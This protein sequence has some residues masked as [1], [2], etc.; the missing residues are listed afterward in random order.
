MYWT[1]TVVWFILGLILFWNVLSSKWNR[2]DPLYRSMFRT[3]MILNPIP[4]HE[5][6]LDLKFSVLRHSVV[7]IVSAALIYWF[8][9][10]RFLLNTVLTLNLL[11][12]FSVFSRYR[13]RRKHLAPSAG[14]IKFC[15][16]PPKTCFTIKMANTL[17]ST[18][19]H[20]GAS[21]G[22]FSAKSKPVNAA[23]KS[24]MVT[25]FFMSF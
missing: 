13:M 8:H 15:P 2:I 24:P 18:H 1:L 22:R 4:G 11:Y 7:F 25:L 19:I 12:T 10:A 16:S 6:Y 14:F 9:D 21:A 23:L 17:P 20:H 3:F 5:R